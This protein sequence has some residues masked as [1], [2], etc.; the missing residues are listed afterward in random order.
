[1]TNEIRVR[2]A[3]SPTGF[4]HLGNVRV[5]L[6]NYLFAHQKKGNFI[7]RIEDTD[8]NRNIDEAAYQII[9]DLDWLGLKHDEGPELKGK[10]G[11]YFQSKRT[12]IYQKHLNDLIDNQKIYRC[13][14]TPEQLEE[15]RKLQLASGQPPRYDRTCLHLSDDHIKEK[16]AT[17]MPFIWRI[18]L[19]EDQIIEINDMAHG[20]IKFEMK[21]FS[22]FALTRHDGSFTFMFANFVDD[23][24]M[25]IS[26]VI[27]GEDHLSN[28]AMQAALFSSFAIPL[29]MFWHLPMICNKEGKKLSKRDFGF[30]LED[31]K[32]DGYLPEA[33]CNYLAI[34]GGTFEQE[35]QSIGEL[36]QNFNFDHMHSTGAIRFDTE[37]LTWVNHKWIEKLAPDKLTQKAK[38]FLHEQIP[39]SKTL[40]DKKLEYILEKLKTDMKTLKDVGSVLK[41]YF[42]AP[43]VKKENLEKE[44]GKNKAEKILELI[45][46]NIK[47]CSKTDFFLD[48]LKS[49]GKE[50]G[51]K[52]KEIFGPIRY[53]LTGKFQGPSVHDLMQILDDKEIE[54][55]LIPPGFT[56]QG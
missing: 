46:N 20:K 32:R 35:I 5:A 52:I 31:L 33:I 44:F 50:Q 22:D 4:M 1:M 45:K 40:D 13:F 37:K 21:N 23:W 11:P 16:I 25:K 15:K 26:H 14:C 42:Q 53:L 54:K 17:G 12:D 41:F 38:P 51:L 18:K 19:N 36:A 2:F 34:I 10:Y 55:R 43:Q 9:K 48:T 3:P 49:T 56:P 24:L 6:L 30:S 29:P 28:T 47:D 39:A 27:R 8:F 7:L